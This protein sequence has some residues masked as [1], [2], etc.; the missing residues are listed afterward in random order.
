MNASVLTAIISGATAIVVAALSYSLTK[1]REREAEWRKVKLEHYREYIGG[2]SGIVNE[3]ATP[4]S[5]ARYSDAVNAL[6]LVAPSEVLRALRRFQ[7][8]IAASNRDRTDERHDALL[9]D[10]VRAIRR[11]I[12]PRRSDDGDLTFQVLGVPRGGDAA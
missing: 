12:R 9:S 1:R 2:L 4:L 10:L 11:D 6:L 3:R 5:Q 7:A 8:E